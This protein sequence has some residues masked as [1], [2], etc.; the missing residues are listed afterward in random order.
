MA[1]TEDLTPFFGTGDFGTAAVFAH[2]TATSTANVIFDAAYADPLGIEGSRPKAHGRTV[3]F[4][5]VAH[6]DKLVLGTSTYD[7]REVRP[8]GSGVT[9]L[10]LGE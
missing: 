4:P 10:V 8:D 2:G 7:I 9:T 3:D 6:G 1:F 5:G